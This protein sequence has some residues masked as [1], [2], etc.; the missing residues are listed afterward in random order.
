MFYLPFTHMTHFFSKYFTYHF[1]RWNDE[2]NIPGSKMEKA[3]SKALNYPINWSA[4]HINCECNP[5]WNDIA[6]SEAKENEK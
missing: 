4:K 2:P 6:F 5:T 1:V 3:L